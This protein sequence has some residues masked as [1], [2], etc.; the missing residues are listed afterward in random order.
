MRYSIQ[1]KFSL[2]RV[3]WYPIKQYSVKSYTITANKP[4]GSKYKAHLM[5]WPFTPLKKTLLVCI[6]GALTPLLAI[7][8]E[9]MLFS[10]TY[11]GK[12]SGFSV[13]TTRT[14]TEL[15]PHRYELKSVAK[16]TFA[17]ITEKS[18][19]HVP[20]QATVPVPI[21]TV[22]P[23]PKATSSS[24]IVNTTTLFIPEQYL[25]ERKILGA[26]S[27]QQLVFDWNNLTAQYIRKD[28][29]KKNK[30]H[31]ILSGMLDPS[32]YQL[33]LQQDAHNGQRTFHY[34]YPKTWKIDTM[35]FTLSKETTFQLDKIRYDA[36]QLKRIN[37]DDEKQ[38]YVTLIPDLHFQIAKITHVEEDGKKYSITL[39]DF[40]ANDEKLNE[41]Y[42]RQL[43]R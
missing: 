25:Y 13:K 14:L 26:S 23:T 39:T 35:D 12:L 2:Y 17:S 32:L 31:Q 9:N 6:L 24:D 22:E 1:H 34:R 27:Q 16:N 29:P 41:F 4:S 28:K 10:A 33:K 42:T 8:Q 5:I 7:S 11:K 15:T 20:I 43:S 36:I 38:T 21:Q 3:A 30:S 19:F 18:F 40:S 37:Q